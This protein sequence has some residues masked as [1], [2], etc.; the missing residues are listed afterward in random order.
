V[1]IARRGGGRRGTRAGRRLIA[2][3]RSRSVLSNRDFRLFF[4][5]NLVSSSG[6]WLQNVA[7]GVLVLQLTGRS[8]MVGATQAATFVPVLLLALHGGRLADRFDRRRLL[9]WT[10]LSAAG[11]TAVLAVLAAADRAG[12]AAIVA[13]AVV[14]GI[15]YAIAIPATQALVPS[16]VPAEDLGPAIG[17]TTVTYNLARA[18]GP[19]LAT[20]SVALLGFGLAFGLNSLS[21]VALAVAVVAIRPRGRPSADAGGPIMEGVRL[22]WRTPRLRGLLLTVAAVTFATDPVF[23]LSPAL[24]HEAFRRATSEAGLLV[25]A[26]GVGAIA[27]AVVV[28]RMMRRPRGERARIGVAAM[29]LLAGGLAGMAASPDIWVALAFLLVSGAGYLLTITTLTTGIQES[30]DDRMRG[31]VMS[32]W[33]LCFLGSRPLSALIDGALA[34]ALSPRWAA[35]I[36]LV[37]LAVAAVHSRSFRAPEA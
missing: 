20:V 1:G 11:A 5:G 36:M 22:A 18:L 33:T 25:S 13:V 35:L 30:V 28:G 32:L 4:A 26:F 12:V 7:Q 6:T 9:I 3:V 14:L 27:S 15:Q 24:A 10:Q 37:P 19:L 31:R 8:V 29:A 2:G 21:F 23:T 16:L 17:L 34:D